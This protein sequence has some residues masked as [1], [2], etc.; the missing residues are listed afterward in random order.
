MNYKGYEASVF[1]SEEDN[2]LIGEVVNIESPTII[3]FDATNVEDLKAEF[4]TTIDNYLQH[5]KS[6]KKPMSGKL[7]LRMTAETHAKVLSVA[8]THGLSANKFINQT[9][10][11]RI[12]A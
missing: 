5:S 1:Y 11:Q 7:T 9:I 6:P 8:R 2:C 10:K 4:H 12:E 3:A